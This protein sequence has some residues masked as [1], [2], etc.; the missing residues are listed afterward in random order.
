MIREFQPT[1]TYRNPLRMEPFRSALNP[2]IFTENKPNPR[3]MDQYLP[4]NSLPTPPPVM[5]DIV[6]EQNHLDMPAS[7][8]P[9]IP[10]HPSSFSGQ[11]FTENKAVN[12]LNKRIEKEIRAYEDFG[13]YDAN[14]PRE[15]DVFGQISPITETPIPEEIGGYR[16]RGK[17]QIESEGESSVGGGGGGGQKSSNKGRPFTALTEQDKQAIQLYIYAKNDKNIKITES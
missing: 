4:E 12:Q 9:T 5:P 14:S 8:A 16:K 15:P 10:I 6:L 7:P 2:P 3:N 13:G 11:G 1:A 17:I